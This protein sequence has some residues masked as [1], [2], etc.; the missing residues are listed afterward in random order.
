MLIPKGCILC[1]LIFI[2]FLKLQNY[3]NREQVT[4]YQRLGH[5]GSKCSY[6]GQLRD[7]RGDENVLYFD[8]IKIVL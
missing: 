1:D 8:C 5:K 4:G 3:R 6:K 2:T 7:P